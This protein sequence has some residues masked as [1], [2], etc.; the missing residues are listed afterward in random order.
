MK[1]APLADARRSNCPISCSL[2]LI[3]DRWTLVVVRDLFRGLTK[4]GE[5]MAGAEGI[6][7]NVLAERLVRLEK[8]GMITKAPYQK[9]PPR[10]AYQLTARGRGLAP[11]VGAVALWGQR[12]LPGTALDRELFRTLSGM[13]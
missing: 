3:G 12:N 6:P 13:A 5:F 11:V 9:N 8:A 10:Y 2:D 7:T 4:F 1:K